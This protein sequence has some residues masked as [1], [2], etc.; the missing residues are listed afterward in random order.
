MAKAKSD[1]NKDSKA[2]H[3]LGQSAF[4]NNLLLRV[5]F[6]GQVHKDPRTP[7]PALKLRNWVF[8]LPIFSCP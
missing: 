2:I 4:I 8:K 6:P 5:A 7:G 3:C 1:Q